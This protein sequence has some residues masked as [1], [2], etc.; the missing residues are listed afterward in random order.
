MKI[1][2][3]LLLW[4]THVTDEHLDTLS[5]LKAAGYDGV[6]VPIFEGNEAHYLAL[7]QKLDDIGLATTV[8]GIVQDDERNPTGDTPAK[9]QAGIDY[10]KWL[11]DCSNALGADVLAGPFY[12]PL[13]QFS[14][15]G[16]TSE[17]WSYL[18]SAHKQMAAYAAGSPLNIAVEPLNRFECYALNTADAAAKLV[19]EVGSD[20]YGYLYDTFHFNIEEK[21]PV[22]AIARTAAQISH[23]HI[24]END[25]GTPGRGHIHFDAVFS[26]LKSVGYGG[27]LTI[28]SFGHALPDLA[29]ATKIWRPIF[30]SYEQVYTEGISLIRTGW[31]SAC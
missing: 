5:K 13:A 17:E 1:G 31:E 9:R 21:D 3:N 19:T 6:E 25:R 27:W 8:V 26:A 24:S 7:K 10:L 20:N 28:E 16:C 29:A 15:A 18:V 30:D 11:V 14:G 2:F 12:Q 22:A 23:V 4:T